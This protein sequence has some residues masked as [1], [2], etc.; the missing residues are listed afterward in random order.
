MEL[1]TCDFFND[2]QSGKSYD[3]I[4]LT[5]SVPSLETNLVESLSIGGRL[6]AIVGDS[7]VMEARLITRKGQDDWHEES[8]FETDL[9]PLLGFEKK[10]SFIF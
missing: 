3:L 10:S 6:F 7:P 9:P 1:T 5:G 4:V 2:W 8:L